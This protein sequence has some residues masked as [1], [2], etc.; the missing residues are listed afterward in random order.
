MILAGILWKFIIYPLTAIW[1]APFPAPTPLSWTLIYRG[2]TIVGVTSG[3]IGILLRPITMQMNNKSY[4]TYC[5]N[6]QQQQK[7]GII[8]TENF[9]NSY[10][11]EHLNAKHGTF[12]ITYALSIAL[13][14]SLFL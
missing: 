8:Y 13:S 12:I 10:T 7:Y 11:Y 2:K 14:P 9:L 4:Y 3:A 1:P 5:L 6:E